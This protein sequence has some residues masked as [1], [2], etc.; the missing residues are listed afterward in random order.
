MLV[1]RKQ[2]PAEA[3]P[4]PPHPHYAERQADVR[5]FQGEAALNAPWLDPESLHEPCGRRWEDH[6][7]VVQPDDAGSLVVCPGDWLVDLGPM[8]WRP[9]KPDMFNLSFDANVPDTEEEVRALVGHS[10]PLAIESAWNVPSGLGKS[11]SGEDETVQVDPDDV[12]DAQPT[13]QG[14]RIGL[15]ESA[16]EI[17]MPMSNSRQRRTRRR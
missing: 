10:Q 17:L 7:W 13:E 5:P 4:W 14:E 15:S 11:V 2:T 3:Y 9:Y 6:G 16:T 12:L 1:T 8:G